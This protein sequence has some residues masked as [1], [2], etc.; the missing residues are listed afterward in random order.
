MLDLNSLER[1]NL[2]DNPAGD[3]VPIWSPDGNKI[4]FWSDR[5]SQ[6]ES[7]VA[8]F[9]YQVCDGSQMGP[10][11]FGKII[12]SASIYVMKADGTSVTQVSDDSGF[13]FRADW[14][15][16]G[17]KIAFDS[18]RNGVRDIYVVNV[19]GSQQTKLT[20][21]D[22]DASSAAWSPDGT[23]IAFESYRDG[24]SEIYVMNADGSDLRRLTHNGGKTPSW[25]PRPRAR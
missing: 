20:H 19:D 17:T 22:S 12:T 8:A 14:C 1:V 21:S 23:R 11:T 6:V 16:D 18:W 24:R 3:T 4:A 15:P 9:L 7:G 2:T 13:D 10:P 5:G 25:Q